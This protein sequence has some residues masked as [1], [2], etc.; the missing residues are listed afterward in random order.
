M[1][2]GWGAGGG[3]GGELGGGEAM[4]GGGGE[5]K[6]RVERMVLTAIRSTPVPAAL[7]DVINAG[8]A[9]V[10]SMASTV[11]L[12]PMSPTYTVTSTLVSAALVTTTS[13]GRNPPI[14]LAIA[15]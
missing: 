12:D 3:L 8:D 5:T 9:T 4:G 10:A 15:L 13:L 11:G 7:T 14:A 2:G 6:R 1:A